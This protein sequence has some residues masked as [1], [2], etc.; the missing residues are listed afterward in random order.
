MERPSHGCAPRE[1][2]R[3]RRTSQPHVPEATYW[4]DE[5][6][7]RPTTVAACPDCGDLRVLFPEAVEASGRTY[8]VCV[9][10]DYYGP[11]RLMAWPGD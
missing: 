8:F 3:I 5:F 9:S 7:G 6:D 1:A 10:C 11:A 4:T 2:V